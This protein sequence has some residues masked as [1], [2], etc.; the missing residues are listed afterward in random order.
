MRTERYHTIVA[1]PPW[2]VSAGR[3][4]GRYEKRAG[5]QIFGV[6]DSHTR[7]LSYPSMSLKE[8]SFLPVPD[9]AERDAHLYLWTI[10]RY[11][12]DAFD[13][14]RAWG[15]GYSTTLVWVKRPMGGGTRRLLRTRD[16][17]RAVWTSRPP[18]RS[19]ADQA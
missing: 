17:V 19:T 16:R 4:I 14:M 15:F 12:R 7:R 8:I 18:A 13:V 9:L 1:D 3:S 11:L 10:N 2:M 5:R 6:T